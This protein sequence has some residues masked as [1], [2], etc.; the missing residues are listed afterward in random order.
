[1]DVSLATVNYGYIDD[2]ATISSVEGIFLPSSDN[3]NVDVTF[4][5]SSTQ[6]IKVG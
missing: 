3:F 1:M 6:L 2:F 5:R 4:N